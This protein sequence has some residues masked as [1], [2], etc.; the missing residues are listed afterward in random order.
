[1]DRKKSNG[2]KMP[3]TFQ[4]NQLYYK[5]NQQGGEQWLT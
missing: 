2:Q 4:D 3:L 5:S 1:M